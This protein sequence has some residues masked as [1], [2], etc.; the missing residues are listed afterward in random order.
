MSLP[1]I[2]FLVGIMGAAF[3]SLLSKMDR[4]LYWDSD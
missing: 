2:E 4:L 1:T 3:A